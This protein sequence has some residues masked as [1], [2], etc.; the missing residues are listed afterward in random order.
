MVQLLAT[1][2]AATDVRGVEQPGTLK[3]ALE[4]LPNV[5][6]YCRPGCFVSRNRRARS[7]TNTLTVTC[8][9]VPSPRRWFRADFHAGRC[10]GIG[11]H[12]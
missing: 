3:A 6:T 7:W 1:L 4:L 5:V 8:F 9:A 2:N 10:E 12:R 11:R